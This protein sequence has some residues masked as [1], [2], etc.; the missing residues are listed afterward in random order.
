MSATGPVIPF[1]ATD[2]KSY[3]EFYKTLEKAI[4]KD[5]R[6]DVSG[7]KEQYESIK[8]YQE[9]CNLIPDQQ[10]MWEVVK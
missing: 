9:I 8:G 4:R 1:S 3:D 6:L 5:S 7:L 2:V 10:Q